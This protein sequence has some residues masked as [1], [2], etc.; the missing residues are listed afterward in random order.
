MSPLPTRLSLGEL[1]VEPARVEQHE[2]GELDRPARRVDRTLVAL[3]DGDRQQAAMIEV[4]VGQE[5]RVE[6]R[7]V[8][9]E[10]YPVTNGFVGTPLE[11]A[12]VDEHVGSRRRQ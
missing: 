3:A 8:E 6:L 7:R 2:I 11:H 12:A 5:N 9:P 10:G 4:G 1:L